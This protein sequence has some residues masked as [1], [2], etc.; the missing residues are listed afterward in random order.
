MSQTE[1]WS[2]KIKKIED[3]PEGVETNN[4]KVDYLL[5]KYNILNPYRGDDWR[6]T[7]YE[8]FWDNKK[9]GS[10]LLIDEDFYEVLEIVDLQYNIIAEANESS[11]DGTVNFVVSFY[12]GGTCIEEVLEIAL[13]KLGILNDN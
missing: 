11:K 2:G 10:P 6:E 4:Q 13:D 7:F 1:Q 5:Q 12:N 3:W 9:K 8:N